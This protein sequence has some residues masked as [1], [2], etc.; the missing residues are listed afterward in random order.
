LYYTTFAEFVEAKA[1]LQDEFP[2]D[3]LGERIP[4]N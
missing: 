3:M 2:L 1:L 4:R